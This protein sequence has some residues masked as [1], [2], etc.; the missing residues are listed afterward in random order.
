MNDSNGGVFMKSI[1]QLRVVIAGLL[2]IQ[3]FGISAQT[4]P[5]KPI[6]LI[7]SAAPGGIVDIYARRHQPHLQAELGQPIV[8]DNKPG[9]SGRHCR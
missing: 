2:L 7:T 4:W 8:V 6:K 3:T 5:T 9:A 1:A